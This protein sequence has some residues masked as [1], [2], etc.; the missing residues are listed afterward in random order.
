MLSET[1]KI[2]LFVV[3][4]VLTA[5]SIVLIDRYE[6]VGDQ[7]LL[8]PDFTDGLQSWQVKQRSFSE[9]IVKGNTVRIRSDSIKGNVQ[10]WQEVPT[11][12]NGAKL[13][14]KAT[15]KTEGVSGDGKSWSKARL[16]LI[17]PHQWQGRYFAFRVV[18]A[19]S[20]TH[21]WQTYSKVFTT[22][23]NLGSQVR[24]QLPNSQGTFSVKDLSLYRVEER[25]VYRWINWL[26]IALWMSFIAVLFVPI[27]KV[28]RN[29]VSF[30]AVPVLFLIVIGTAM[31]GRIKNHLKYELLKEL[32]RY[33]FPIQ[34]A[35]WKIGSWFN[36]QPAAFDIT[37]VGHFFLFGAF[38]FMF[39]L[40]NPGRSKVRQLGDIFMLACATE[41]IQFYID[42]RSPLFSDV[43]IDMAGGLSALVLYVLL[44]QA[45]L[46]FKRLNA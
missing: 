37:K 6:D 42:G 8:N 22:V 35:I 12:L 18:A 30:L 25:A 7:L 3:L 34:K 43:L 24:I 29:L 17:Q 32:D 2:F 39:I 19:L 44:V 40:G 4:C 21:D 9:V 27:L 28:K 45:G 20:G 46:L 10:I 26:F 14:L 16:L 1:K 23:R 31:S 11:V 38:T 13:R 15:L 41:C 5:C 36:Y 33:I